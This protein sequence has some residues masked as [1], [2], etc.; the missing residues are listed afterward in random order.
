M[1]TQR[2]ARETKKKER[3]KRQRKEEIRGTR[4]HRLAIPTHINQGRLP[5]VYSTVNNGDEL[6]K[7]FFTAKCGSATTTSFVCYVLR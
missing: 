1:H 3:R 2:E 6:P 7:A 5:Y 4:I